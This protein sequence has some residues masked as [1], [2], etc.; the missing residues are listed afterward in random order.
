MR[1]MLFRM[2]SSAAHPRSIWRLWQK[3]EAR[4][5]TRAVPGRRRNLRVA[6]STANT[7]WRMQGCGG[8]HTQPDQVVQ[9]AAGGGGPKPGSG[10]TALLQAQQQASAPATAHI[11]VLD[12]G[13]RLARLE[14]DAAGEVG[15]L[16]Q[17]GGVAAPQLAC[18]DEDAAP[19]QQDAGARQVNRSRSRE[20][21]GPVPARNT[22][23]A[24]SS[25]LLQ[26]T[27]SGSVS[28]APG[29]RR[30]RS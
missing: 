17:E 4:K 2:H 27:R 20:P 18:I 22:V 9:G 24:Q 7:D 28:V 12:Q 13:L 6:A 30:W 21:R 16:L 3:Q 26:S 19:L 29:P 25:K 11:Q 1:A 14:V 15:R 5:S 10:P 23:H 8:E